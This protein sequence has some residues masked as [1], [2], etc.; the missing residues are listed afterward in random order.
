[1]L[2][3]SSLKHFLLQ[4]LQY[5]LNLKTTSWMTGSV[6]HMVKAQGPIFSS[7]TNSIFNTKQTKITGGVA[8]LQV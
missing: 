6:A 5:L 2:E 7:T 3:A 1:V 8:A 4:S